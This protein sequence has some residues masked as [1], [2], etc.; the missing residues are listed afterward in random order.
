M[1]PI[2]VVAPILVAALSGTAH[3]NETVTYTYDALGRL[4]STSTTGTINNGVAVATTYDSTDNR[5]AHVVTGAAS[6]VV[7]VP[8]NGFT[9]IPVPDN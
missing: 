3:A 4:V 2:A 5:T 9:V 7:V 8:L 6:K 1:R